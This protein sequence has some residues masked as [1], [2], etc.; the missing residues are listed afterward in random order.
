[1]PLGTWGPVVFEV[2]ADRVRTW[3]TAR[4]SGEARWATQEVH[5]SKP[6][7]EFLGPGLDTIPMTVKLDR[8]RGIDVAQELADLREQRD[9]GAQHALIVGEEVVG[10]FSL[11][12]ISEDWKRTDAKG[13]LV[14]AEVELTFKEYN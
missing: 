8:D 4:R 11:D 6:K 1:M 9:L 2:S 5:A 3:S 14:A 12:A 7:R 13:V 10:N